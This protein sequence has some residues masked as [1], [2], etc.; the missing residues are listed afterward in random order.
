MSTAPAVEERSRI[1]IPI[2]DLPTLPTAAIE[3]LRI[4]NDLNAS[5]QSLERAIAADI[6]L[7]AR[8]LQVANSPLFGMSRTI[9][10]IRDAVV[11][12]GTRRVR[13][14]ASAASLAPVFSVHAGGVICGDHLWSHGLAV[15]M[16]TQRVGKH[17]GYPHLEHVFTAGLMHDV[18]VIVL[19]SCLGREYE[20]IVSCARD[21]GMELES[22][23][24]E[25]LGT[26][27]A[28]LA[29]TMCAKWMLS[30]RLTQLISRHHAE[31]CPEDREGQILQLSDWLASA[32]GQGE[33]PWSEQSDLNPEL[34]EAMGI[35]SSAVAMMQ[36]EASEVEASIRAMRAI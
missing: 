28:R 31:Q 16:W 27:H 29:A 13:S 18:G 7:A 10:S 17:I 4:A 24:M 9:E 15:A 19:A 11:L 22:L 6:G 30:P 25:F 33:F 21:S 1:Y 12:L 26:D 5:A 3:A 36:D 2:E 14:I 23:E 35:P 32:T 8:I 34:L 20:M